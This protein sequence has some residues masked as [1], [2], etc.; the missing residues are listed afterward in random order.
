MQRV[1]Q[2]SDKNIR[3]KIIIRK[4]SNPLCYVVQASYITYC[5]GVYVNIILGLP[6]PFIL[7]ELRDNTAS[8]G[9]RKKHLFLKEYEV[10]HVLMVYFILAPS[11]SFYPDFISIL[12]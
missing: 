10:Y 3:E 1:Q 2:V 5:V 4:L 6:V 7:G 11:M 8:V 9:R 12:S